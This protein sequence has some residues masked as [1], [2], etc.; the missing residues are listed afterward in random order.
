MRL[1]ICT[2]YFHPH[3][4]G[5]ENYV[6][7]LAHELVRSGI[8]VTVLTYRRGS[9]PWKEHIGGITVIRVPGWT[10][11]GGTFTVPIPN[12]R[13]R[14]AIRRLKE[15]GFTH[16]STQTRFFTLSAVGAYISWLTGKPHIHTEHGNRHV[17]HPMA[18]V[19][20]ASWIYDHTIGSVVLRH[21]DSVVCISTP[22]ME[23]AEH[24]GAPPDRITYIPNGIPMTAL[25]RRTARDGNGFGI[26]YIGR[27]IQAK[28]VEDLISAMRRMADVHLTII[29]DGPY[30]EQLEEAA[31]SAGV[32]AEFLG[33]MP[34]AQARAILA[35][36]DL[37]VNPSHSEGLPTSVIEAAAIGVPAIATDVGGTRD[38]L[39][40]ERL[41]RPRDSKGLRRLI[42]EER[43]AASDTQ[44]IRR[45]VRRRF[46]MRTIARAYRS[47]L[48]SHK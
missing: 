11:L 46:S 5:V 45:S 8:P 14:A 43:A 27:L 6:S 18:V 39:P 10:V 36:A 1:L 41:F 31:R 40:P 32:R 29:G 17:T 23:F 22:G 21:A 9:E 12:E 44:D 42:A 24:L 19:R 35:R 13:F 47:L 33:R 3:V 16:I 26:V 7:G 2:D 30:R 37:S 25:P 34:P 15:R 48:E 20:W 4:G 38:I 28:G